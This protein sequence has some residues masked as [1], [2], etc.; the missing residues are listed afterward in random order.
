MSID[1]DRERLLQVKKLEK[2]QQLEDN[3]MSD[4]NNLE[5]LY[6][7]L[8]EEVLT[9]DHYF[10]I[11]DLFKKFRDAKL[12][13]NNAE[14]AEKAQWEIHYLSFSL[15]EGEI[16]PEWKQTDNGQVFVYPHL[17]IF[18]EQTYE[19]LIMR[20][21][22]TNH[23]KL[24]ARYAHILWCSPEKHNKYAKIAVDSYL[25]LI[26]IYEQ[27]YD[28][29]DEDFGNEITEV[30]MNAYVIACQINYEVD[31][32][33]S[34]FKR[35]IQKFSSEAAYS[36]H[37]LIEFMLKFK[38]RFTKEDFEGIQNICWQIAE[39]FSD[40][41]HRAID[42]L[43]LG[44]KVDHR[45]EK[46]SHDWVLRIAQ[47][48]ETQMKQREKSPL[49]ALQFCTDAIKYYRQVS[50]E[51]KVK[52]LEKRYSEFKESIEYHTFKKDVD[53]T[54]IVNWARDFARDFVKDATSE[55][56]IGCLISD[57]IFLPKFREAELSMQEQIKRSP[58]LHLLPKVI[59]DQSRNTAQHFETDDEKERHSILENY[60]LQLEMGYTH[61]INAV[62]TKAI[63]ERK[64]SIDILLDFLN[65]NCWYGKSL[66]WL[67]LI[68]PALNE[69]F[70]QVDFHLADPTHNYPNFVLSLD[71]LTLKIEGLFRHLCQLSGV[72]TSRHKQDNSGRNIAQEKDIDAL[73]RED[74]IQKLFDEDDL[75]FF[76]FLL[77]DKS[78][79]NLRHKI[80]HTLL[81]FQAY[82]WHYMNL[83]ILALLRLGKY[84]FVQENEEQ[85]DET[86]KT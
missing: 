79:Y 80:A 14:E 43:K 71:S 50:D 85:D 21:S 8:E 4:F 81:P 45:L 44:E 15:K 42:F 1:L 51:E 37:T 67:S 83:M 6:T 17:D 68:A 22:A 36:A 63:S 13:E 25:E 58:L 57:K 2:M 26:T 76:K 55:E 75:L 5:T 7:H 49:V 35:L 23:P 65:K 19:Y 46:Q 86:P 64:L 40:D 62:L 24:K 53:I 38:K 11:T 70:R 3:Q 69:Y 73:L 41:G 72:N 84:D 33:K 27:R 66:N 78:G 29:N 9:Y 31:K 48:F 16:G 30:V 60:R 32:I 82:N 52:E 39:S 47:H 61:L 59:S 28:N 77:V 56:I 12:K 34:E 54:E 18:D 20:L 10:E 74:T